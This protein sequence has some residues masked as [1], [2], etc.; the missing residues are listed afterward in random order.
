M[1][2]GSKPSI[3]RCVAFLLDD[4][5]AASLA[6][7]QRSSWW[8]ERCA[9]AQNKNVPE[10]VLKKLLKDANL[11]VQQSALFS[12]QKERIGIPLTVEEVESEDEKM[13]RIADETVAKMKIGK[14]I[15]KIKTGETISIKVNISD[16]LKALNDEPKRKTSVKKVK[17]AAGKSSAKKVASKV[18]ES[19]RKNLTKPSRK[20]ATKPKVSGKSKVA[21]KSSRK[22]GSK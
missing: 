10:N 22:K 13:R 15:K 17:K 18:T 2:A 11:L 16:Y 20:I 7:Y 1:V 19:S 12:F 8:I 3:T 21:A 9:I 5:P 14:Q 6:K 4:C